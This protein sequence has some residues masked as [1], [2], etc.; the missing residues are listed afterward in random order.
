MGIHVRSTCTQQERGAACNSVRP[1][2]CA[3][4]DLQPASHATHI[5]M[6][7]RVQAGG[8][9]LSAAPRVRRQPS[10]HRRPARS[11]N[12]AVSQRPPRPQ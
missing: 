9:S 11:R 2:R 7:Q 3:A 4:H 8:G 12:S 10:E 5:V 1:R 6:Q